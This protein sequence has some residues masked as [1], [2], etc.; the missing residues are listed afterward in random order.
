MK[1]VIPSV[2][3]YL[4]S[5]E[6]DV[7]CLLSLMI[8]GEYFEVCYFYGPVDGLIVFS[9]EL[10]EKIRVDDFKIDFGILEKKIENLVVPYAQIINTLNKYVPP[11][12]DE[13]IGSPT[14]QMA[15]EIDISE[16]KKLI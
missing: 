5:V 16:V 13:L 15:Q 10:E 9:N 6:S 8:E 11:K 4:G 2:L 3:D 12:E 14:I 1:E 7:L